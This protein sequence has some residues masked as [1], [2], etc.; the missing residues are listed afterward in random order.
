ME[1]T[2]VGSYPKIPDPPAPG[3]WRSSVEKHQRGEISAADLRHIEDEVTEEVLREQADA[4]IDVVTDGQIR[5]EDGLT[6]FARGLTGFTIA[7]LQRYFDTNVYYRQPVATGE[8]AWRAP[9]TVADYAFAAAKSTRSVKPVVTGP[10]TLAVMSRDEHYRSL[11]RFVMALAA[12]LNHEVRAL[13]AA[14]AALIQVDEPGLLVRRDQWPLFR[15]AMDVLWDGVG[16]RRALYTYFGHVDG[17]YPALLD[18]PVDV[19]GLDFVAARERNWDVVRRAPFTKKLGLGVLDARNTRMETP[20]DIAIACRRAA[21]FVSPASL[22][23]GPSA[24]L[25]FLPR[26][27]ARK[28]LDALAAGVRLAKEGVA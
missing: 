7:G 12:A 8:V 4:G 23:V 11:D 1:T 21:E 19:I 28:K 20:E 2:V 5:W 3:R 27:V 16:A 9:I 24:G 22:H 26:R 13:A 25:E 15:R 6:Y 18:L 10:L 17:L 14:G